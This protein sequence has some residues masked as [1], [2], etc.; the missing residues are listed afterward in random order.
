MANL[1]PNNPNKVV[2]WTDAKVKRLREL[3]AEGKSARVIADAI[4]TAS[5]RRQMRDG[6]RNA[7][8][9]KAHREK[10]QLSSKPS[11]LPPAKPTRKRWK[12]S[13]PRQVAP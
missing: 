12:P 1:S 3:A 10:I 11:G 5:E 8:I 4:L 6:G 2:K 13:A 7:V 9:G